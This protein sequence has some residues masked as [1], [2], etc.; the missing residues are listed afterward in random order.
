MK[1][2]LDDILDVIKKIRKSKK[3]IKNWNLDKYF[4]NKTYQEQS[5]VLILSEYNIKG[6]YEMCS[7][8]YSIS[9]K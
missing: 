3:S 5:S 7:E 9:K 6:G 4:K 2:E 1:Y 8:L